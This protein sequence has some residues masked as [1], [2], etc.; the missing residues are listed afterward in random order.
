MSRIDLVPPIKGIDRS[1]P[2]RAQADLTCPDAQNVRDFAP[3]NQAQTVGKRSGISKAFSTP[4][5]DGS[6]TPITGICV[7]ARSNEIATATSG[8]FQAV[9][10]AWRVYAKPT[11]F[12]GFFYGLDLRGEYVRFGRRDADY[13]SRQLVG[14][15]GPNQEGVAV[16]TGG[17][18]PDLAQF[19]GNFAS[20]D[21][22]GLAVNWETRNS[23]S[24]T[25]NCMRRCLSS[26]DYLDPVNFGPFVRG[27]PG[28]SE[29]IHGYLVRVSD[30]VVRPRIDS[31]I[32]NA[33]TQLGVGQDINLSG[34]AALSNDLRLTLTA[35]SVGVTLNVV[36]PSEGVSQNYSVLNTDL[37]GN[38]R[39]GLMFIKP[40]IAKVSS[41]R[42]Y[43]RRCVLLEFDKRVPPAPDVVGEILGSAKIP[44]QARYQIPP[45]WEAYDFNG[46]GDAITR[47]IASTAGFSSDTRQTVPTIDTLNEVLYGR[48]VRDDRT[49]MFTIEAWR[50]S[51]PSEHYD[52]QVKFRDTAT[53]D[54]SVGA[55]FC[56][57]NMPS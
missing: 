55:A 21:N 57:V 1:M 5:G 34:T 46:S 51:A 33:R 44:G 36:W 18:L 49:Q 56:C 32:A 6:G 29:F 22:L 16:I 24:A 45:N 52:V 39:A 10:D 54:D 2:L 50:T 4:A 13:A 35:T 47:Q 30:N 37:V 9:S 11:A 48:D 8:V 43:Y 41:E 3:L 20:N 15:G 31:V 7:S 42:A 23:V 53:E 12:Q 19:E 26:G 27:T 38:A 17:G 14:T 28:L 25:M 40:S